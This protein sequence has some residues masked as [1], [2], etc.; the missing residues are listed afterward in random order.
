MR[1]QAVGRSSLGRLRYSPLL[2]VLFCATAASEAQAQCTPASPCFTTPLD[3]GIPG[4]G[5]TFPSPKSISSDGSVVAGIVLTNGS[6]KDRA[7]RWEGGTMQDL[8]TLGGTQASA[9]ALSSDGSVV[10]GQ[11]WTTND[12]ATHAFRWTQAGGMQDLGTFG[13]GNSYARGLS[14]DGSVVVGFAFTGGNAT[15]LAFR[16]ES[17]TLQNLGTLGGS[18]SAAEAVS[19]DGSVV[20]GS[21]S[22]AGNL[23]H[24]FRWEGSAAGGSMQDLE[25]LGGSTSTAL[26]VSADGSVVVG[27]AYT[28]GNLQHAFRWENDTMVDI[29]TLGGNSSS[30]TH[31]SSD[32]S[33]VVGSWTTTGNLKRAFRWEDGSTADLGT[34]G[35]TRSTASAISSDGAVVVGYSYT[36]GNALHAF[37]WTG[38]SGMQDLNTLLSSAGVNMSGIVLYNANAI[39]SNGQFITGE[40]AFS[41]VG[42]GYLVRYYDGVGGIGDPESVQHSIN[43]LGHA[44]TGIMAQQQGFAMP[45]LGGDKPMGEESEIGVFGQAGSAQ[46]GGYARFATSSGLAIL[47]GVSYGQEDYDS[48][49]IDNALMGALAVR[50]RVPGK[51]AWRP[52]VEAGGWLAP[53]ADMEFSRTYT[54]GAGTATGIGSTEGDISYLYGRAGVIFAPGRGEQLALSAELGRERLEVD[55]YSEELTATN[56]F[57]A[58]VS[59]GTDSMDLVKARAQWSMVLGHGFDATLWGAGVYGFNRDTDFTASVPGIGTLSP[60]EDEQTSWAECGARVGYALTA[61]TTLDVFVNGVSGQKDEIDTRVHGGGGLRYRF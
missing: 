36:A 16:W 54:N 49:Q 12:V 25:T 8:G 10:I 38:A 30:A 47:A 43:E 27:W 50:Y 1:L 5:Y 58:H 39:S 6:T 21:A 52:F 53:Q 29:D 20:V 37:R 2:I 23:E 41:G 24:A 31:V 4:A 56:P 40:G 48:A 11:S 59:A 45:L 32:G 61:A 28:A 22:T 35:G 3:L 14:S 57:E 7:F 17:G 15:N 34:L 33:V 9:L 18:K 55:A 46:G 26:A 60:V 44:R 51:D 13:G 19:A 42:R